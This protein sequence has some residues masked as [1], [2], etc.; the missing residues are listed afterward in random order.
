MAAARC[1]WLATILVALLS[2][3]E[4]P[5]DGMQPYRP[6]QRG[7]DYGRPLPPG[8]LALRKIDPANWPDFSRAYYDRAKLEAAINNS[9]AYLS[10]PSSQRYFPYGPITHARAV[11]SLQAFLAALQQARSAADLNDIIRQR[12]EVWQSVG[13]DD[14]GTVYFTGY[15]CPIFEGRRQRDA[16]FRY[17]LYKCPPDLVKN[18]EGETLGR[19]TP[20]GR[21][22]RPYYTRREIEEGRVLTGQEVAWLK[23]PFE[24]YVVTIQGS[25]K[26][27]MA[28]GSLYE[29]GYSANNGHEYRP[30]ADSMIADGLISRSDLSL[31]TLMRFFAANPDKV[32]SYCWQNPRYVFFKPSQGGP[33]GSLNVPVLD[34]YSL[35]TDKQVFPRACLGYVETALPTPQSGSAQPA[36]YAG[37]MLDQD[38]GGAIRAAGRADIYLGIGASA[39]ALAGRT[40]AEGKLYYLFVAEPSA[41]AG[42]VSP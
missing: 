36:D 14:R 25:A 5:P 16:R 2:G 27:R 4:K 35:A 6:P 12:F 10:K 29:L 11:A 8:Q 41:A 34:Y 23:D 15:Y 1:T 31:Q 20:D 42:A 37:F 30:V 38:T 40:G 32:Y 22:V 26:L 19:R 18:E 33:Y 28:D 3:C 7:K 39:E 24:A 13:C 9:L 17:P 21:V